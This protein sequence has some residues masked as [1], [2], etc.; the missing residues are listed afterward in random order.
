MT[1][2][3]LLSRAFSSLMRVIK[4]LES[5]KLWRVGHQ[6]HDSPTP[7]C[8]IKIPRITP[9]ETLRGVSV[10]IDCYTVLT[11][12]HPDLIAYN[13]QGLCLDHPNYNKLTGQSEELCFP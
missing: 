2:S 6:L 4:L 3:T 1:S 8:K 7:Q 12:N 11:A 5:L 10:R 9:L 13:N